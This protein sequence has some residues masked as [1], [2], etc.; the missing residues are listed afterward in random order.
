MFNFEAGQFSYPLFQIILK[1][2]WK[3]PSF[4]FEHFRNVSLDIATGYFDVRFRN[5]RQ[6]PNSNCFRKT[7]NEVCVLA[8]ASN[9]KTQ[10][11]Y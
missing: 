10:D 6:L 3:W 8:E 11:L 5:I 1:W 2:H 9:K 4:V 7:Q